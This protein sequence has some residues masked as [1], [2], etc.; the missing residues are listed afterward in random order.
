MRH[1]RFPFAHPRLTAALPFALLLTL[2]A[3]PVAADPP[4][5]VTAAQ[6]AANAA[7]AAEQHAKDAAN[8]A[9]TALAQAKAALA[10]ANA[11]LVALNTQITALNVT[12]TNDAAILTTVNNELSIDRG[13]LAAY[14]RQSYESGGS[15]AM[16]AYIISANTIAAAIQRDVE[17]NEISTASG[18]LVARIGAEEAK[19]A[20]TLANDDAA[21]ASLASAEEQAKTVQAVIKVQEQNLLLADI[22][23]HKQANHAQQALAAAVAALADARAR[24]AVYPPVAGPLFTVDTNLTLPSGETAASIDQ[25]LAGSA[26]AGLGASFMQAET[27]YHV[28]ARYFVAHAILESGWGTSAI[29]QYKFNLFGFGAD[30]ANPF[31]DAMTFTSF[32]A[33]IQY[34]AQFIAANYLS[35]TGRFYHGPTLRGM[36]V[37]YASDPNWAEKIAS[38]ADTIPPLAIP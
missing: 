8:N 21:L 34:V 20:S 5:G 12:I 24:D 9:D 17:V 16:L 22:T 11:H 23:A 14:I 13:H 26:L 36:N 37:D 32:N 30:D 4:T 29:A 3:A 27:T 1:P 6:K 19:A 38:I 18:Q 35:P 10:A 31:G 28:S 2:I 25:F 33:C 7:K 15:E